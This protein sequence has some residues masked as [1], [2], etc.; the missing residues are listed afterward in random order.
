MQQT[1]KIM[2]DRKLRT[3]TMADAID[4]FFRLELEVRERSD[5]TIRWYRAKLD[6]MGE[7]LGKDVSP[8]SV[9]DVDLLDWLSELGHREKRY[10]E[11]SCRPEKEG[12]LAVATLRG[13]VRAMRRFWSWLYKRKFIEE[14]P[15]SELPMPP[16]EKIAKRGIADAD[17]DA[18]MRAARPT[19]EGGKI[20]KYDLEAFRDYAVLCFLD[21]TGCRLGGLAHLT[22]RDID[23]TNAD[24]KLRKRA[25]VIEKGTKGRYVFMNK[26]TIAA[27]QAW[28]HVRPPCDS[29]HVFVGKGNGKTV[30]KALIEDGLYTLVRK[31][32]KITGVLDRSG[33]LWSPHQWRHRF[34]RRWLERG[35]D[36]SRLA[37]LLGHSTSQITSEHYGQLE[38]DVLQDGY[39]TILE[40][41]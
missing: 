17:Q 26:Q 8:T 15:A 39:D 4:T 37:Q 9:M 16:K 1:E 5:Q 12:G 14:N 11:G 28:L 18:M 3:P 34:G 29:N 38:I 20:T 22:L 32:A 23:L 6:T 33:A 19:W 40:D 30:W 31:Y 27:M 2:T 25:Y 21:S 7:Y 41:R 36:L 10:G 13:H 35:G 24:E